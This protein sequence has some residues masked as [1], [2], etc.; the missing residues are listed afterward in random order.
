MINWVFEN[1]RNLNVEI[2]S[3][4]TSGMNEIIITINK[5]YSIFDSDKLHNELRMVDWIF[6]ED[7]T[8]NSE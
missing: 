1:I 8:N 5:I 4:I 7:C 3:V 6:Y 2:C